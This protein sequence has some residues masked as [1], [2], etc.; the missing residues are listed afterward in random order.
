M[1]L[2]QPDAVLQAVQDLLSR[3]ARDDHPGGR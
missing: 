3:F 2:R 1:H